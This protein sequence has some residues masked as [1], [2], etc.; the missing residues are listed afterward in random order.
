[1]KKQKSRSISGL[2]LC[3][4]VAVISASVFAEQS[5]D[6]DVEQPRW[7]EVEIILY[8]ASSDEGLQNESWDTDSSMKLPEEMID[9]LQP[10]GLPEQLSSALL[11]TDSTE[12]SELIEQ[13]EGQ[14]NDL[15]IKR[16]I[17]LDQGQHVT[18]TLGEVLSEDSEELEQE[19]PFVL[20]EDELLQ[21]K[22]EALNISR[23]VNYDLL[24]H[25]SWRQPV[26]N[27][28]ETTS[29][30]I[31]GG[32][33]YQQSF[34]FSGEKKLELATLNA[35]QPLD[36]FGENF[37]ENDLMINL[38]PKLNSKQTTGTQPSEKQKGSVNIVDTKS[39]LALDPQES[40][41]AP[42]GEPENG[43]AVLVALP[44]VPEI[45]GS[46]LV[47]I[48]RNY[49]HLDT[50]LYYRRPGKEQ[51]DIFDFQTPLPSLDGTDSG[52]K[53][54]TNLLELP[55]QAINTDDFSWQYDDEFLS[56]DIEQSYTERLFNYPLKQ[57]RRLRSN[58]L[59]YFDHPLIGILVMIRPYELNPD[60]EE[61][62]DDQ[63]QPQ[64][65]GF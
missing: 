57:N 7:F 54:E 4:F 34:E 11:S 3:A 61:F 53:P 56:R 24:A 27:K 55:Q 64:S 40:Q 26:L 38:Q 44:W 9:F 29:L 20:L 47:Y 6:M 50:D 49:L 45:D 10:F 30:R 18:T 23:H 14:E 19:K 48:H 62:Q 42:I 5:D 8:K 39:Q 41:I 58:Q 37:D 63:L 36:E 15:L 52:L 31:A 33:D 46:I 21:L 22:A 51:I 59:H 35:A 60:E 65:Q 16:Q 17:E 32:F 25:F 2:L 13:Q 28:R 12:S 1:M 43:E